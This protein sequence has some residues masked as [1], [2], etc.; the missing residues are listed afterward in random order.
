MNFLCLTPQ[1]IVV[2]T[3]ILVLLLDAFAINNTAITIVTIVGLIASAKFGHEVLVL[4]HG[5]TVY[6]ANNM[7]KIDSLGIVSNIVIL[8]LAVVIILANVDYIKHMTRR[9]GEYYSIFMIAILGMVIMTSAVHVLMLY[10]G[11]ETLSLALLGLIAFSQN[12]KSIE[13]AMKFFILNAV[14]SSILLLG[15][16]FLYLA[17]N[18][19]LHLADI[20]QAIATNKINLQITALACLFIL[21]GVLFKVGLFPFHSWIPDVYQA[22][23]FNTVL[24]VSTISKIAALLFAVRFIVSGFYSIMTVWQPIILTFAILSVGFGNI[25]ALSQTNIKRMLGYSAVA[26]AGFIAIG[27]ALGSTVSIGASMFY[28]IS[29]SISLI[30]ALVVLMMLSSAEQDCEKLSD[31]Q[32][33]YKT[34]KI[35]AFSLSLAM[36]S[37]AGIPPFVGFIAKLGIIQALMSNGWYIYTIALVLFS[38]IGAFYYLRVVKTIYFMEVSKESIISKPHKTSWIV[39]FTLTKLVFLMLLISIWPHHIIAII[40]KALAG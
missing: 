27:I 12:S 31:I 34:N 22:S 7:L 25:V 6:V 3:M 32:G 30:V 17:T 5:Q 29:Y 35:L 38:L 9:V 36:F 19:C 26:N 24:L 2:A 10:L 23:P 28:V 18:G 14:A 39:H 16:S 8:W 20:S 11:L 15:I 4:L 33:L 40:I 37:I 13:A 1:F 21:V